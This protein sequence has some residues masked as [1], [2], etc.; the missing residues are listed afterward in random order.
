MNDGGELDC[1]KASEFIS[2]LYDG[3]RV[4]AQYA[5]HVDACPECRSLLRE[6]SK[7][8]A[9][10]RLLA[11]RSSEETSLPGPLRE[12]VFVH[13]WRFTFARGAVLVPRYAVAIVAVLFALG[14]AGLLR[15][16]A[17]QNRP[18]WFEYAIAPQ[19]W[20]GSPALRGAVTA[21]YDD[22]SGMMS[23][24]NPYLGI[25]LAV[26]KIESN[27]V[28]IRLRSRVYPHVNNSSEVRENEDLHSLTGYSATF[29]VGERLEMPMEGGGTLVVSGRILDHQPRFI[30]DEVPAE[31]SPDQLVFSSPVLISG[32]RVLHNFKGGNAVATGTDEAVVFMVPGTGL[33][34]FSLRPFPGAFP[35][36]AEWG[37]LDFQLDGRSYCMLTA[38]QIAGGEQ[39]H[40]IWIKNDP[41]FSKQDKQLAQGLLAVDRLSAPVW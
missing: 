34:K 41:N 39:P 20:A 13:R 30:T 26:S 32:E 37:R 23:A 6:Y 12:K 1:Q 35:S 16:N 28:E 33:L 11:S 5:E 3:E 40:A 21:G 38:S 15:L 24:N 19:G 27:S 22:Y 14:A 9:E 25:H 4:P 18:L 10:L 31:P 17:Q 29:R 36:E 7:M 8:G 2:A